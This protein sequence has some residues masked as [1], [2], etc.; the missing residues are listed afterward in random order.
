MPIESKKME[1]IFYI[2]E[3]DPVNKG[4]SIRKYDGQFNELYIDSESFRG[5]GRSPILKEVKNHLKSLIGEHVFLVPCKTR[6]EYWSFR[7]LIK[8]GYF[9]GHMAKRFDVYRIDDK[10]PYI[11]TED[12]VGEM[13]LEEFESM[14]S[15][16]AKKII[17]FFRKIL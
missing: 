5:F 6:D 9:D 15:K 12:V 4:C 17:K 11:I 2:V 7:N 16:D 8:D 14:D 1:D 13:S 10:D 3:S